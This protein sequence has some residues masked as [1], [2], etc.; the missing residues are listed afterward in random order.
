MSTLRDLVEEY[1]T[2]DAA[3][4]EHLHRL[5]GEWQLVSDLS[6]AD[7]LLWVKLS[8]EDA[9]VCIAQVRPTTGPT[10]YEDDQV[11][12]V[13]SGS[14]VAH[15][16]V[17]AVQGRIWREG[18]PVWYGDVPARNEAIPVRRP[19]R[20]H[21]IALIGRD[22]NLSTARSPSQLELNYLTTA[23][24]LAQMITDGTF[25]PQL[26]LGETTTAPRVGDGLI[27]LDAAGTVTYAS[28]NALS[29]YRRL[30]L[31]SNLEGEDL[32]LQTKRLIDDSL[33]A[34]EATNR[35]LSAL[36]GRSAA[37]QGVGDP[38]RRRRADAGAAAAAGR[39]ADRRRW[40]WSG[41][42][43]RYV[44]AT[45]PSSRRTRRSGRSTTG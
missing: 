25:P 21:V 38:G 13:A 45:V 4:V 7:L 30:G 42:S 19:G 10:A 39:S 31:Q 23:D 1:T 11:G 3:D 16:T 40:S 36:R 9:F 37:T 18:D 22:T 15:L 29:A 20:P 5:A 27:R 17:A 14:D 33:D 8:D 12:R 41:T 43:P 24:D 44:A 28:P 34:S 26:H 35:I 32:A 6:F 2:L